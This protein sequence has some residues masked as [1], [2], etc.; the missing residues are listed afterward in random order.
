MKYFVV[1]LLIFGEPV[2]DVP[3]GAWGRKTTP[4]RVPRSLRLLRKEDRLR[5]GGVP[6]LLA[7][8][9]ATGKEACV[10]ILRCTFLAF[11]EH[12]AEHVRK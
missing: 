10:W 9:R 6:V 7:N 1:S 2:D 4:S 11:S 8:R 5:R 12:N 3:K